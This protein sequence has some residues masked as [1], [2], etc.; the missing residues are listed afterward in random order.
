MVVTDEVKKVLDDQRNIK[1]VTVAQDVGSI[2]EARFR[3]KD[4]KATI[5]IPPAEKFSDIHR[6]ASSV[7]QTCPHS[8]LYAAAA[9]RIA[10]A[11]EAGHKDPA[12]EDGVPACKA[13]LKSRDASEEYGRAEL[14]ATYAT[15]N[16]VTQIPAVYVPPPSTQ[17]A[18]TQ[19]KSTSGCW[20]LFSIRLQLSSSAVLRLDGS[21]FVHFGVADAVGHLAVWPSACQ[22]ATRR[23]LRTSPCRLARC[24][25]RLSRP[26][27]ERAVPGRTRS[28]RG[29]RNRPC[30]RS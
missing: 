8:Q 1:G 24:S 16:R 26:V 12:A 21:P 7:V 19:D 4:G 29:L 20:A 2:T 13:P 28:S 18:E 25:W 27:R 14:A 3:I 6:Q 23:I 5:E 30:R 22:T 9:T 17:D 15:L 10:V 11:T